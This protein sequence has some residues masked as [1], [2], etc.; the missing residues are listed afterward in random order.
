MLT[1]NRPRRLLPH[2]FALLSAATICYVIGAQISWRNHLD[3]LYNLHSHRSLFERNLFAFG[4]ETRSARY[5][6]SIES[7][8]VF[9]R[10]D[11]GFPPG[12]Y[13]VLIKSVPSTSYGVHDFAGLR[14]FRVDWIP[15]ATDSRGNQRRLPGVVGRFLVWSMSLYWPLA[16]S[17]TYLILYTL[18][19]GLKR[20]SQNARR[21]K[22]QCINCGYDLR[23]TPNR[24]PECGTIPH[25]T[26]KTVTPQ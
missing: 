11:W 19:V 22:N 15:I 24:C 2:V 8:C 21:G 26:P 1:M 10:K 4:D 25:A 3:D 16:A 13:S 14:V 7:C 23:A 5:V 20:R 9:L 6:L 17:C 18:L 12:G